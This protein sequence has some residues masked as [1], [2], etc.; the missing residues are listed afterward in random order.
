MRTLLN[1][2]LQ[3]MV[4]IMI[5]NEDQIDINLVLILGMVSVIM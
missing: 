3:I 2:C 5:V 1:T 4:A